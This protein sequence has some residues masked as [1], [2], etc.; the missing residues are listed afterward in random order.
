[1]AVEGGRFLLDVVE[2]DRENEVVEHQ[3]IIVPPKSV[4]FL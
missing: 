2:I 1:M 4:Q 3:N